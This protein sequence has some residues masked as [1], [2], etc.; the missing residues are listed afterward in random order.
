MSES[1]ELHQLYPKYGNLLSSGTAEYLYDRIEADVGLAHFFENVDMDGLREHMADL[2]CMLTGGP[3]LYRGRDLKAAHQGLG[4]DEDAF[5]RV[6]N[7]LALAL[8]D[9]GIE[10]ADINLILAAVSAQKDAVLDSE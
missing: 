3:D 4:I 6:A 10:P 5:G 8:A 7:H 9:A 2:L 1:L